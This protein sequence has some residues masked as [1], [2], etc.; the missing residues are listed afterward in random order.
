MRVCEKLPQQ[1]LYL[2]A[3]NRWFVYFPYL[4]KWDFGRWATRGDSSVVENITENL[5]RVKDIP[6]TL[7]EKN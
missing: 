4:W 2:R 6:L 5:K 1:S 3:E 7:P